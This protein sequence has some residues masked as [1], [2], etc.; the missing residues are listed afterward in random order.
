MDI[1]GGGGGGGHCLLSFEI[2]EKEWKLR[3]KCIPY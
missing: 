3:I 2:I 1:E